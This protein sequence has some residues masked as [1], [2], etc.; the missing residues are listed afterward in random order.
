[1]ALE[2]IMGPMFSGKTTELLRRVNRYKYSTETVCLVKFSG[3]N[4]YSDQNIVSH[5]GAFHCAN[6]ITGDLSSIDAFHCDVYAIDEAQF[7]HGLFDFVVRALAA[8]VKVI[9]SCL[10]GDYLHTSFARVTD[11]IPYASKIDVLTAICMRCKVSEAVLTVRTCNSDE[12]IVIGGNES[13]ESVCTE[14]QLH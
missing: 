5:D 4:R 3:D 9:V 1:M 2:I 10:N 12:L 7:Y 13:Y 11:I 6:L 14:C 8:R